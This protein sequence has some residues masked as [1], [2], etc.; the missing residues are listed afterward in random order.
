MCADATLAGRLLNAQQR[1]P[2]FPARPLAV[3]PASTRAPTYTA[4]QLRRRADI[5]EG[6]TLISKAGVVFL[7]EGKDPDLPI[8]DSASQRPN[9]AQNRF[10]IE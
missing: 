1:A 4:E 9:V 7:N 8:G 5:I 3:T 6:R 10:F 2:S